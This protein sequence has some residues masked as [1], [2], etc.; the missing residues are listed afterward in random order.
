MEKARNNGTTKPFRAS[1]YADKDPIL[2][3]GAEKL[4]TLTLTLL[5]VVLA[6]PVYV[7]SGSGSGT[8]EEPYPI[9]VASDIQTASAETYVVP[10]PGCLG[11]YTMAQKKPFT[12]DLG[13][14]LLQ[15]NEV[16]FMCAGTVTAG[17]D[18]W[19]HPLPDYF[20]GFFD[21][22]PGYMT[23]NGPTVGASTYPL[24]EYF[25]DNPQFVPKFGATWDFLLDGQANGVVVLSAIM[26]IP[27]FPPISY[28]TG[29]LQVASIEIVAVPLLVG[30]FDRGGEVDLADFAILALAW[31]TM[32][33]E[34]A[35]NA[36]CDISEP[37][38]G[39]IDLFDIDVFCGNWL[40][41]I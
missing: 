38:D 32:E 20:H 29:Y 10:L 31:G 4:R 35:Y 41:G 1:Y 5:L 9:Y 2:T 33:G 28:P 24:P 19:M 23:A 21:T 17:L 7:F 39:V 30:D 8:S 26:S 6:K 36:D 25:S 13:V 11:P 34:P 37:A 3:K 27:E 14:E 40:A 18:Y 16:R 12:I 15:I 22:D